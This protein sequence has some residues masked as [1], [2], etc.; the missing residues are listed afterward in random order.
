MNFHPSQKILFITISI[1]YAAALEAWTISVSIE[2]KR[3]ERE[4]IRYR[5]L[6][7]VKANDRISRR[8]SLE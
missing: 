3:R 2:S 7:H 1:H 6:A 8:A 4:W 5:S